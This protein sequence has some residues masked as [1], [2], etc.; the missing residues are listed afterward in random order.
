MTAAKTYAAS[1]VLRWHSNPT[2]NVHRQS[3]GN[4]VAGMLKLLF[5]FH[6]GPSV[7]LVRAILHHDDGE[8][9]TGDNP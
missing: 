4:H 9:V 3:N 7:D 2:M 6:P 8:L 1:H 5:A